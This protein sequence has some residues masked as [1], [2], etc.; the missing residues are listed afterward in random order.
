MPT[1]HRTPGTNSKWYLPKWEYRTVVAFCLQYKDLVKQRDDLQKLIEDGGVL[2][3]VNYDGMPHGTGVGD[4]TYQAVLRKQLDLNKLRDVEKKIE[5]IEGNVNRVSREL[6]FWMLK[7]VTEE[8]ATYDK[9]RYEDG[10]PLPKNAY[11]CMR[12]EI[13]YRISKSL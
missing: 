9:L 12:R 11:S 7:A 5:L 6:N 10:M 3:G 1:K 8:D 13:Y 4:P 2:K